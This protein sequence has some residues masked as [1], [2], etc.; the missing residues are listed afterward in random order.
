[1]L[2]TDQDERWTFMTRLAIGLIQGCAIYWAA[3]LRVHEPQFGME[4]D[5]WRNFVT[6]VRTIAV[7]AP[8]PLIFGLGN[9]PLP[10]L[11]LWTAGA[12]AML[13]VVGW[14]APAPVWSGAP[15]VL[16]VWLFSLIVIFIVHE[17]L[18]AA[19]VDRRPIADFETYFDFAWRH[20]FQAALALV[21]VG[22]FWA[23]VSLGAWL[24]WIIGVHWVFDTIFSEEF[25]WISSATAFA[26]GV[27]LTDAQSGLTRGAREIGLTLLSWLALLMTGILSAFLVTLMFTGLQPLWDTKNATVLLL[28]AGA[29]MILLI[30]A[31]F[32]A[33]KPPDSALMR[34]VVRFSALPLAGVVVLA[35]LGLWLRVNQYGLT[36]ARVLAG[37]ELLVVGLH[38][39]GYLAAAVKPGPWMA[40]VKP[41]NITGAAVVAALLVALMTPIADPARLSVSNQIARLDSGRVA[42]EDFDFGFLASDRSRHWGQTALA[43]LKAR[44]GSERDE[45]IAELA[46]RL[47]DPFHSY[48]RGQHSLNQR[49]AALRL[50]GG[51]EIPD[52]A[53]LPTG[54][55]DPVGGCLN[56]KRQFEQSVKYA[57]E[58][59]RKA[60]NDPSMSPIDL[61]SEWDDG[62][63][64]ARLVDLDADGDEDLLMWTNKSNWNVFNVVMFHALIQ[65]TQDEWV[66]TATLKHGRSYGDQR[67]RGYRPERSQELSPDEKRR[68]LS[69]W[70]SAFASARVLAPDRQDL[71]VQGK[72]LRITRPERDWYTQDAM[73]RRLNVLDNR[74]PPEHVLRDTPPTNLLSLC[75]TGDHHT[76]DTSL[77]CYGQFLDVTADDVEE[78]VVIQLAHDVQNVVVQAFQQSNGNWIPLGNGEIWRTDELKLE[79]IEDE[80]ER[81][82]RLKQAR[83]DLLNNITTTHPLILDVE[84]DGTRMI[85][86]YIEPNP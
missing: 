40:L 58:H 47:G 14:L 53:L 63:C 64:P 23:V 83:T 18:Q 85:I 62:Q 2:R 82:R 56:Q 12:T 21:F 8:L 26:L 17:F 41:V 36:P 34:Q 68:F 46:E 30:N 78:Y 11:L 81:K 69:D 61:P 24:F 74:E 75:I 20:G 1:M 35:A 67:S 27:H 80:I 33:G 79:K 28:N 54:S 65:K 10:R 3:E 52:A 70:E 25:G 71:L 49:R 29:V 72:R 9:L 45:R 19:Y 57:E 51:G 86:D 66:A 43:K 15:P 84:L 7:F 59:R 38:A 42:P 13:T 6:M 39:A 55:N 22:A 48:N 60:E 5:Q 44:S 37:A 32:Q 31:A 4:N 77:A 50:V 73:R 16:T 76:D